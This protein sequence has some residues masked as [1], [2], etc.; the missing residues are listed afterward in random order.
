MATKTIATAAA[1]DNDFNE[2]DVVG[3]GGVA[4]EIPKRELLLAA[5]VAGVDGE[6]EGWGGD[7]TGPTMTTTTTPLVSTTMISSPRPSTRSSMI[8][9]TRIPTRRSIFRPC[10]ATLLAA[11]I[12]S[13]P[14]A[15]FPLLPTC[16]R[17]TTTW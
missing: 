1:G 10:C 11:T 14:T 6:G 4:G 7:R 5:A 12:I 9:S 8:C 3:G 13:S 16:R 15:S 17:A 2:E